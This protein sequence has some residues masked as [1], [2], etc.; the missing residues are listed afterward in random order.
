MSKNK[1]LRKI[2]DLNRGIEK[3][4]LRILLGVK[5][6]VKNCNEYYYGDHRKTK[7]ID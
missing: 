5:R 7:K 6:R 2:F 1:M 3:R 4:I